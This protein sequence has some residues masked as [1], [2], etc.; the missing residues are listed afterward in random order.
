MQQKFE[1]CSDF[2]INLSK[3]TAIKLGNDKTDEGKDIHWQ[4]RGAFTL[5]GID[6]NRDEE[7]ITI[8]NTNDKTN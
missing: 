7:D 6:F 5:L 8:K 4:H 2:K 3:T 1:I